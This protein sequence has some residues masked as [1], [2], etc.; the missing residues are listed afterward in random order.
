VDVATAA[1]DDISI[2]R[3]M[4]VLQTECQRKDPDARIIT[5]KMKA[6]AALRRKKVISSPV[7]DLLVEFPPLR[8]PVFVS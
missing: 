8:M 3:H 1:E 2:A 7:S 6:I 4:A 5:K